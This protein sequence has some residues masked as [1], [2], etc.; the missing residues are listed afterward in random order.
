MELNG[1]GQH[2]E[3]SYVARSHRDTLTNVSFDSMKGSLVEF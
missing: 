3:R 1:D 2:V